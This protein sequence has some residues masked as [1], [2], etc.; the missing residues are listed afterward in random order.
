MAQVGAIGKWTQGVGVME[1]GFAAAGFIA[2]NRLAPMLVKGTASMTDKALRI[3][4]ALGSTIAVGY[5]A[6]QVMGASAARSAIIGGYAGT[7][8]M[9]ID[10]LKSGMALPMGR[11][12]RMG[13]SDVVSSARNR[14]DETVS[15]L[16]P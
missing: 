2:A 4:A 16:Q 8:L 1:A 13:T 14:D 9:A 10:S 11:A 3:V 7:V 15:V 5:A 12:V 6:K